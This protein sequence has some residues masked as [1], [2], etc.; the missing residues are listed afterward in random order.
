MRFVPL[1]ISGAFCVDPEPLED[2]RGFFART[3][4]TDI[5]LEHGLEVNFV[6]RSI[7]FN[8]RRGT[9]RGLHYQTAPHAE[10]KL[11]RCIAGAALDVTVDLRLDSATYGRWEAIEITAKNRRAVYVPR[12]CAHGFQTLSD[13]TEL[14]YDITPQYEPGS[15][16]GVLW[17]D[18]ELAIAW[19]IA[20]P[21]MSPRDANLPRLSE[22]TPF[23]SE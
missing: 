23:R 1:S 10:T 4:S 5:F 21:V 18:P 13:A 22:I 12:G 20:D 7:S 19:P 16:R 8:R 15:G 14:W 11:V 2:E 6:Q 9:L 17:N 3:F